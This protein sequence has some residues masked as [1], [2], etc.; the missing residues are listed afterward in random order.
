MTNTSET[1]RNL[2]K[3]LHELSIAQRNDDCIEEIKV[4]AKIVGETNNRCSYLK[5][6]RL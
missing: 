2:R 3:L 6:L 4:L 1:V 5:S